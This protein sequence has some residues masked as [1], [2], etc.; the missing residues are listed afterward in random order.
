MP[1]RLGYWGNS[2][3]LRISS[4]I[5]DCAHLQEGDLVEVRL[6]DDG[7]IRVRPVKPRNGGGSLTPEAS[8]SEVRPA[9]KEVW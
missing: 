6:Q 3:S 2:L 7:E 8:Q 5:V 4:Y 9:K 1:T